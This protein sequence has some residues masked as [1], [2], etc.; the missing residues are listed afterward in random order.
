MLPSFNCNQCFENLLKK[1]RNK[2]GVIEARIDEKEDKLIIIISSMDSAE[3][4][5]KEIQQWMGAI[6]DICEIHKDDGQDRK[7]FSLILQ[8][9]HC[10]VCAAKIERKLADIDGVHDVQFNI[11]TKKLS[12]LIDESIH[13]DKLAEEAKKIILDLEPEVTVLKASTGI[14]EKWDFFTFAK[15]LTFVA[16]VIFFILGFLYADFLRIGF[17]LSSY[18]I[19][20]WNVIYKAC[21]NMLRKDWFDE[22]FLMTVATFGALAIGEY[23]EAVAVMMFFWIGDQFQQYAVF[24]SRQSIRSVMNLRPEKAL[25]RRNG[26]EFIVDP[27]QIQT[28]DSIIIKP[29]ERVPVDGTILEGET[30]LDLSAL[31]GESQPIFAKKGQELLSGSINLNAMIIIRADQPYEN[32]TISRIMKMV[33]TASEKKASTEQLITKLS[34][35]YTPGVVGAAAFLAF[36][37]P[38]I[39]PAI[40]W[41]VWL[42]RS[43]VFLVVSCPCALVISIPLGFF[44]GLGRASR[45]G[46]LIKGGNYLEALNQVKTILFDK[47]G[48]LTQ[49][50]FKVSGIFAI[51]PHSSKEVLQYAAVAEQYSA[52]PFAYAIMKA[53]DGSLSTSP[54]ADY[55]EVAGQGVQVK[56]E[57][58]QELVFGNKKLME[59][60][61]IEIDPVFNTEDTGAF[62]AIDGKWAGFISLK[63][64]T[65]PEASEVVGWLKRW[66]V[67]EV[68]VLTGDQR[69]V[70]K[71]LQNELNLDLVHAELLPQNKVDLMAQ[72][73]EKMKKGERLMFVGDGLND[74]PVLAQADIGVAMGGL[75][76]DAAIEAS[77]IVLM[78]QDLRKLPQAFKI[79]KRTR[80]I[81]WQNII[82]A[83]SVKGVVLTLGALGIAGMWEAVFADVGVTLL[84]V[85]NAMRLLKKQKKERESQ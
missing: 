83:L 80:Q 50:Q 31:T 52:H 23:P 6:P 79:A 18:F 32:S 34:R 39:F 85:L 40:P 78:H 41:E 29:G 26:E 28:G 81:V 43:F 46:I 14:H 45:E 11:S 44:S 35:Y 21:R 62:L 59:R 55:Y 70:A 72:T 84:A 24:Q 7:A 68:G 10:T 73:R 69:K 56:L 13:Q 74:A 1:I 64:E 77:D 19:F 58:Q 63:D 9:L 5:I 16:G 82:F 60:N 20:G 51:P 12:L 17:F 66:G 15:I 61:K 36:V 4:M 49:G 3:G 48:T 65:K 47:T 25:V 42:Y 67:K 53:Y 37:C 54:I 38:W 30:S 75:G 8:G 33:E 71:N 76:S 57:N 27:E 2:D 22:N